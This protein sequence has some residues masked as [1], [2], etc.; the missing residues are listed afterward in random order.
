ME[1]INE[2]LFPLHQRFLGLPSD[3]INR[4]DSMC[5]IQNRS[6]P[7]TPPHPSI[8]H[9]LSNLFSEVSVGP[10]GGYMGHTPWRVKWTLDSPAKTISEG[11]VVC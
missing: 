2:E 8:V 11:V 6:L 9:W 5:I 1:E 3:R 10:L 7:R 4:W